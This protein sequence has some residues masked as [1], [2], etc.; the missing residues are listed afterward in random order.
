MFNNQVTPQYLRGT[1][2]EIH[3]LADNLVTVCL[4]T[5]VGKFTSGHIRCSPEMLEPIKGT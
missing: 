3:E 4:D 1:T 5:P 2:G